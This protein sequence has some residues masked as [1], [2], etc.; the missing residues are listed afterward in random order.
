MESELIK[1]LHVQKSSLQTQK[2]E[3]FF[4]K[5][6]FE[7][8]FDATFEYHR[9]AN[10]KRADNF[11]KKNDADVILLKVRTTCYSNIAKLN[12]LK[13]IRPNVPI[14]IL[15]DAMRQ[16]TGVKALDNGAS[17]CLNARGISGEIILRSVLL[18]FSRKEFKECRARMQKKLAGME[19][20]E[21]LGNSVRSLDKYSDEQIHENIE[22]I[23]ELTGKKLRADYIRIIN[24]RENHKIYLEVEDNW[25]ND[26]IINS[27]KLKFTVEEG[28]WFDRKIQQM[29]DADIINIDSLLDIEDL[30]QNGRKLLTPLDDSA[31]SLYPI[32]RNDELFG[33]MVIG[34]FETGEKTEKLEVLK[35]ISLLLNLIYERKHLFA[36][37]THLTETLKLINKILRHDIMNNLSTIYGILKMFS[38]SR[39]EK[40]I[41]STTEAIERSLHFI[42][43]MR[44]YES[45]VIMGNQ[46][47]SVEIAPILE[48]IK[49][50]MNFDISMDI[51]DGIVVISDKALG[52]VLTNIVQNA[53]RH[54]GTERIEIS[55]KRFNGTANIKIADFGKG[56]Q[57]KYK[58]LIFDEGF[59]IGENRGSGLGLYI[60]KEVIERYNGD[61]KVYDNEPD[62]TVFEISLERG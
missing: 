30:G 6:E 13:E 40:L 37:F 15:C 27:D 48:N 21:I 41:E 42:D 12:Q 8:P 2:I 56:I 35:P 52:S 9:V 23:L 3:T 26:G 33:F 39:D 10:V 53:I 45:S 18:W 4:K 57:D 38:E 36:S 34:Y 29:K 19:G 60:A 24:L 43:K 61:I 20:M 31:V 47:E 11:F 25:T 5:R 46:L 50:A 62:G 51:D 58:A 54:S 17:D 28:G 22:E 32:R 55:A 14:I 49:D 7:C 1:I 59:A 16:E 44:D